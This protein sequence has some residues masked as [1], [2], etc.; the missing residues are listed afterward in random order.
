QKS[1][2]SSSAGAQV[3]NSRIGALWGSGGKT[4]DCRA[5][6]H[7]APFPLLARCPYLPRIIEK[8][9]QALPGCSAET[10]W[11]TTAGSLESAVR[12]PIPPNGSP[13]MAKTFVFL[14]EIDPFR[15][16]SLAGGGGRKGN[17]CWTC[18]FFGHSA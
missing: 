14:E 10:W 1:A 3:A 5:F 9:P 7:C 8:L 13:P 17:W 11:Q 6:C 15:Q 18:S 4:L 12:S 16:F 2:F